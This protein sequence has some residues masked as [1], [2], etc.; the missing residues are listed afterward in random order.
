[1]IIIDGESLTLGFIIAGLGIA[2]LIYMTSKG[3]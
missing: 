1:M 3:E 2:Y